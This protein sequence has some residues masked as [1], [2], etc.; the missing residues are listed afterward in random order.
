MLKSIPIQNEIRN[1]ILTE[2][3]PYF[4]SQDD[5]LIKS[6]ELF[7]NNSNPEETSFKLEVKL[8]VIQTENDELYPNYITF[9]VLDD[10]YPDYETFTFEL[11]SIDNSSRVTEEHFFLEI[12][13]DPFGQKHH[14]NFRKQL[15]EQEKFSGEFEFFFQ[16]RDHLRKLLSILDDF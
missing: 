8:R 16:I 11:N 9:Y 1:F 14:Y 10:A 15:Y 13:L 4:K 12:I 7:C 6:Y 5:E 2:L 3:K